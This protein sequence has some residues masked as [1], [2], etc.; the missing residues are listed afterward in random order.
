MT[1]LDAQAP[2][3]TVAARLIDEIRTNA[4]ALNALCDRY[5]AVPELP[6]AVGLLNVANELV[7][8]AVGNLMLAAPVHPPASNCD[9][10]HLR[11][12]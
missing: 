10:E 11:H 6:T 2:K 7:S 12:G 9:L 1:T 3:S 4:A 8:R 5:G